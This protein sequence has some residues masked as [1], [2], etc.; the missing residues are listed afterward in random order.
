MIYYI[1]VNQHGNKL[2]KLNKFGVHT[3]SLSTYILLILF[4]TFV[5]YI[6]TSLIL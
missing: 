4:I 6:N 2:L 1:N 5:K 3:I